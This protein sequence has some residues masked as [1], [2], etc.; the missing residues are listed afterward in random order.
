M[1]TSQI[2]LCDSTFLVILKEAPKIHL[3]CAYA[4]TNVTDSVAKDLFY[5]QLHQ[6]DPLPKRDHLF[7]L[8][9]MNAQ[10]DSRFCKFPVHLIASDNGERMAEFME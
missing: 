5:S 1:N 4:S 8:G 6:T 3:V 10:L 2:E 9:D 7:V